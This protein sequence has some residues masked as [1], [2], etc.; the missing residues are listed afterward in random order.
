MYDIS[1]L[2]HTSNMEQR[3]H[4]LSI[5]LKTPGWVWIFDNNK[6]D[7]NSTYLDP[8][9][10]LIRFGLRLF[11]YL[12]YQKIFRLDMYLGWSDLYSI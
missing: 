10:F 6:S 4:W 2:A 9:Q 7:Q 5:L 1:Q 11:E 8:K 12:L 3:D